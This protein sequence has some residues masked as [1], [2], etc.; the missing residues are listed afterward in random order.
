[1]ERRVM[2]WLN[3]IGFFVIG[4]VLVFIVLFVIVCVFDRMMEEN[5]KLEKRDEWNTEE[6][7]RNA[8]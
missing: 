7:E 6:I 2:N 4:I 3:V 1:M 8:H 5:F